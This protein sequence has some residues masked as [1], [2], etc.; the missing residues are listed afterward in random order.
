MDTVSL[1][2]LERSKDD[3]QFSHALRRLKELFIQ[4]NIYWSPIPR[5]EMIV[6]NQVPVIDRFVE[7]LN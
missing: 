3:V 5:M 6:G 4:A 1:L 2:A 7:H